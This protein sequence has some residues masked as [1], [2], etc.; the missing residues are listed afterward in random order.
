M[1][2]SLYCFFL[3]FLSFSLLAQDENLRYEDYTYKDN[4][5]SVRFH[6]ADSVLA[7]PII[8][9]RSANKLRLSFD[10]IDADTKDYIYTITLCDANWQPTDL[11]ELDYLDGFT[12]NNLNDYQFSYNTISEYTH[13]FVTLPNEDVRW[14]RSGNYLLKVYEDEEELT[15]AITRRFVVVEKIMQVDGRFMRPANPEFSSSHQ[16]LDF[17]VSHPNIRVG[18]AMDEIK[19]T[20]LQNGRWDNALYN[21]KPK[22][23]RN[24]K[25]VFDYQGKIAFPGGKEFR[26]LDLRSFDFRTDRIAEIETYDDH[27]EVYLKVDEPRPYRPYVYYFDIN[28]K[29]VIENL[30]V[31]LQFGRSARLDISESFSNTVSQADEHARQ[32][33]YSWVYFSL[34]APIPYQGKKVYLFGGL[35]DWQILDRYELKYNEVE[36][37]YEGEAYLKQGY[38][39]YIY[40]LVDAQDPSQVEFTE[41]EGSWHETENNYTILVY[42]RPFGQRYDRVAAMK[43][44]N[45]VRGQ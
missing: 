23:I 33:D 24:E 27:Y 40:A 29:Y 12:E 41:V 5:Q 43:T 9:L 34:H 39:N 11:D 30:D 20:L 14:T 32:G 36:N 45:S 22:F 3:L 1:Y 31:N 4:I 15:L 16:E 38:Y 42:W 19:V 25:L 37:R 10:D 7:D 13:F 26:H 17:T 28:G 21:L 18:N 35:T 2:R 44:Y 6:W 8:P